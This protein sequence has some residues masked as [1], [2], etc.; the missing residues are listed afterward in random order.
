MVPIQQI[1]CYADHE[2]SDN[3]ATLE[4]VGILAFATLTLRMPKVVED[5]EAQGPDADG[6]SFKAFCGSLLGGTAGVPSKTQP[7]L[8]VEEPCAGA[9][10]TIP[11]L[12]QDVIVLICPSCTFSN[13]PD[14]NKCEMCETLL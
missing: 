10:T 6:D 8:K 4:Q 9:E 11:S 13:A 14:A 5:G 1:L 7:A 12:V 2:L 3:Q